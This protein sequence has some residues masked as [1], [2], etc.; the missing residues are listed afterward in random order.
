MRLVTLGR[1][2][3]VINVRGK[4]IMKVLLLLLL[5]SITVAAQ[6]FVGGGAT[7]SFSP[8]HRAGGAY[9]EA[10]T[11]LVSG[12]A[13]EFKL[14]GAF[15][16]EFAG[17]SGA[18]PGFRGNAHYHFA[19][20]SQLFQPFVGGGI[21]TL[22]INGQS[23]YWPLV[24]AGLGIKYVHVRVSYLLGDANRVHGWRYGGGVAYPI[25]HNF[26][27]R[28]IADATKYP[29]LPTIYLVSTGVAKTF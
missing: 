20:R 15:F 18:K 2:S 29:G 17:T 26:E 9:V 3:V 8:I 13:G 10:G 22:R 21:S 28:L 14:S 4:E 12:T 19:S 5:F 11:T 16:H 1:V 27:A 24:T 6:S 7:T 23:N 25:G